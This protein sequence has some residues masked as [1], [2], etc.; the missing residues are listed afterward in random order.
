MRVNKWSNSPIET[1]FRTIDGLTMGIRIARSL[2][3]AYSDQP[4]VDRTR[5]E[6]R[7]A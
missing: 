2:V 6:S 7:R 1:Q 4:I 5:R 3:T